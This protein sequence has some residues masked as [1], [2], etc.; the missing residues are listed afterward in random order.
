MS[1][2]H[3]RHIHWPFF[4][5]RAEG[6]QTSH[7]ANPYKLQWMFYKSWQLALISMIAIPIML[8][9]TYIFK[10]SVKK[11]FQKVRTQVSLLNAFLIASSIL[12]GTKSL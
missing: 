11:A 7:R 4:S 5:D 9:S 2:N 6:A 3:H 10:E 8:I 12:Y 1:A